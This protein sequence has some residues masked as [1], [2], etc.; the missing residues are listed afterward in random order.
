M[1]KNKLVLSLLVLGLLLLG[2]CSNQEKEIKDAVATVNGEEISRS[3]Y[4]EL[5]EMTNESYVMQGIDPEQLDEEMKKQIE[6]RVVNQLIN[7]ELLL[8]T[9]ANEGITV[10]EETINKRFEEM[11]ANFEDEKKFQD[12]LEK[13]KLTEEELKGKVKKELII[14]TYIDQKVGTIEVSEEEITALYDQ[15]KQSAITNKQEVQKFEEIKE[16]IKGQ[17]IAQKKQEKTTELI[18]KLREENEVVVF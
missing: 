14:T 9:A 2:A 17:A 18:D 11:K 4:E 13:N 1:I 8:Q 12:A 16:A 6:E 5:L 15:Y 3:D 10:D 7:T